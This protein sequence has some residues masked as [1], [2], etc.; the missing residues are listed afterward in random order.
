MDL[1]NKINRRHEEAMDFAEMAFFA[2]RRKEFNNYLKLI[3]RALNYEKAAARTLRYDF[4]VEPTRSVLYQSA[5]F[6]ALNL[7]EFDEANKL[8][9]EAIE[10]N[11]PSIIANE[12]RELLRTIPK[13]KQAREKVLK[14]AQGFLELKMQDEISRPDIKKAL[15]ASLHGFESFLGKD[16]LDS[17]LN[18]IALEVYFEEKNNVSTSPYMV[19]Q[20]SNYIDNK[21]L[22]SRKETIQ[23]NFWS[24]YR[25]YLNAKGFA[26]STLK[27]LDKL[28]DDILNRLGDPTKEG[29]W[30]KRGL[31]VGDVQSGKTSNYVGL[32]N[33]AADA[34]FRIIIILSGIHESLRQQTQQRIDEGFIGSPSSPYKSGRI[35]AGLYWDEKELPPV[36]PF[37]NTED[38]GDLK[39]SR[40]RN[41]PLKTRDYYVFVIKKNPTVLKNLLRSLYNNDKAELDG[42]YKII[43]NI[44]LL[45]I[46]DEADYA[47][48]NISKDFV[49]SINGRIRALLGLF[50]QSAFI[51]YTATPFA[52]IFISDLNKTKDKHIELEGNLF[53]LGKDLFPDD[54]IINAPPPSNYIG[55]SK[56]FGTDISNVEAEDASLNLAEKE[57]DD[58][59]VP[60]NLINDFLEYIPLKHG[61][62]DTLPEEIPTSMKTAINC[63][64]I[65]CATRMARGQGKEHNSMLIHVSWYISWIG[66]VAAIVKSY[67]EEVR[68]ALRYDPNGGLAKSLE[69]LWES[70]FKGSAIKVRSALGYEDTRL[71]EHN[72]EEIQPYLSDAVEKILVGAVH[73]PQKGAVNE[74]KIS[75]DYSNYKEGLSVIA[76]GG[77][78]LSRG[79]TL[80][81]LSISYFLRA[82]RFYDT[83]MQMGRWFG[84][85]QG[86]ADLCRLFTTKELVTWYQIIGNATE[87]L[88]EQFDIMELAQ[89]TPQNYGL[90]VN[91]SPGSI[92]MV[93]SLSKM[94]SAVDLT[95]SFSGELL[96]TYI[97]SK[98]ESIL[99]ANLEIFGKL[100]NKLGKVSGSVRQGQNLIWENVSYE[101]IY[102][103]IHGYQTSQKNINS[104]YL[105]AYI[106]TQ[107]SKGYLA[108]WTVVVI[109]STRD[110]DPYILSSSSGNIEIGRTLR[111]EKKFK[112]NMGMDVVDTFDYIIKQARIISPPHEYLDMNETDPRLISARKEAGKNKSIGK[113]VR[114]NR[115][116]ENALLLIYVL[117]PRGFDSKNN[118]PAIGYA[119]SLPKIIDDIGISYMANEQFV[120]EMDELFSIP[121]NTID[122]EDFEDE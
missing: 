50:D 110:T 61:P 83:L 78:K 2:R 84:Y 115:G 54:F 37:T 27:N 119:M 77:N 94:K 67:V 13:R 14:D 21:W 48:I 26:A 71:I 36:H 86:Y 42:Q 66:K 79:L 122:D 91:K 22:E 41:Y 38:G 92:L 16:R 1:Q 59:F 44:P 19:F 24:A 17:L 81:G 76:V 62:E 46:D 47:S 23:W 87:D 104:Q 111:T 30:D 72:W 82:T 52:N 108:N 73:G 102:P 69:L 113:F 57:F 45:V 28:T 90:K 8:L 58:Q 63:F 106:K 116:A 32:I 99:T 53:R 49:S 97:I 35:G 56:F 105:T 9:N 64:F 55:Y 109:N 34:G 39:A 89:R 114:R 100:V 33:K 103:F 95:I 12:I 5:A 96:E 75:L 10:G 4:N 70:E 65:V 3:Q 60:I 80:E 85:R 11:P 15:D 25:E 120:K 43:R 18:R 118:V 6:L 98:S 31:I 68:N 93:T 51:G 117:D 112:D 74:N 101:A 107:Q 29:A 121:D 7:D 88:K 20:P 40:L